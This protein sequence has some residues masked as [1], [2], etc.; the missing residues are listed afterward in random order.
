MSG[1]LPSW[2]TDRRQTIDMTAI[3]EDLGSTNKAHASMNNLH[4]EI[5]HL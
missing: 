5:R 4:A 2:E 1:A 3:Q